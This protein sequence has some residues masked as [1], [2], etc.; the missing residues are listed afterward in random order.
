MFFGK[1]KIYLSEDAGVLLRLRFMWSIINTRAC[2]FCACDESKLTNF[3]ELS[4]YFSGF[5]VNQSVNLVVFQLPNCE[6]RSSNGQAKC[7]NKV[8]TK[9][10]RKDPDELQFKTKCK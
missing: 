9:A 8:G 10:R 6:I 3:S 1:V 7:D 2:I 5:N 4:A